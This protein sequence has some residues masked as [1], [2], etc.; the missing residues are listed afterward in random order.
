MDLSTIH[1]ALANGLAYVTEDRKQLG[2]VLEE[3]IIK[4]ITLSNLEGIID[5]TSQQALTYR[6]REQVA[7]FFAGTDLA[8]PGLVRVEEWRPSAGTASAER[9]SL[10]CAVGRKR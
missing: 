4:N 3:D 5:R 1:K 2:L 8:D 6:T 7:Q 10:W 9:S